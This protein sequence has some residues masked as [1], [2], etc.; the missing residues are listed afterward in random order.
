VVGA[1]KRDN[2]AVTSRRPKALP[3]EET[4]SSSPGGMSTHRMPVRVPPNLIGTAAQPHQNTPSA[5][6]DLL[7]QYR[8]VI[9]ARNALRRYPLNAPGRGTEGLAHVRGERGVHPV[10]VPSWV[11]SVSVRTRWYPN[12]GWMGELFLLGAEFRSF[13]SV[14]GGP[15]GP[16]YRDLLKL[17]NRRHLPAFK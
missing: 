3:A 15:N 14:R 11:G 4:I 6:R 13:G 2:T 7:S 10:P 5:F 17:F 9:S 8:S 16:P 12:P 1:E